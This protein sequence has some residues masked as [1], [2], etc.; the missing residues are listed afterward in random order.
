MA[1]NEGPRGGMTGSNMLLV[2]VCETYRER[3]KERERERERERTRMTEPAE[4]QFYKEDND[5]TKI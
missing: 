3:G 2:L 4:L 1:G 5:P